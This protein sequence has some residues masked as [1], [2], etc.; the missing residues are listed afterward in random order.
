[1]R[2]AF[3]FG[4]KIALKELD[5]NPADFRKTIQLRLKAKQNI[6]DASHH[7]QH[8]DHSPKVKKPVPRLKKKPSS[9]KTKIKPNGD[10]LPPF[11]SPPVS[12]GYLPKRDNNDRLSSLRM[13]EIEED[14][15]PSERSSSP[16]KKST[17]L[18]GNSV[19]KS[20]TKSDLQGFSDYVAKQT[21]QTN[22]ENQTSEADLVNDLL[23]SP[24]L[25]YVAEEKHPKKIQRT[26]KRHIPSAKSGLKRRLNFDLNQSRFLDKI[27]LEIER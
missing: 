1:M 23:E 11:D 16:K 21:L 12:L 6:G 25:E 15:G 3:T 7:C 14:E 27:S 5:R 13:N 17:T 26:R 24:R 4:Q 8:G 9:R 22:D 19:P 10:D 2:T 18:G 20:T